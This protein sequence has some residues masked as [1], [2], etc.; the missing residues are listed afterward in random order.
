MLAWKRQDVHIYSVVIHLLRGVSLK[1]LNI[2]SWHPIALTIT[3][4][5]YH[6]ITIFLTDGWY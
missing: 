4:L 6:H 3:A 2:V 5:S 1:P